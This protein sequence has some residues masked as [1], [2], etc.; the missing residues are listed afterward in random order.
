MHEVLIRNGFFL[1][2]YK[3]NAITEAYMHGIIDN[4]V[5][6]PKD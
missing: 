4:S 6:C 5:F 1:L 3:S 2:A